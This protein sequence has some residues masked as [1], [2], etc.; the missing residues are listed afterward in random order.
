MFCQNQRA[1]SRHHGVAVIEV[2][3]WVSI[4]T[5]STQERIIIKSHEPLPDA[6]KPILPY[7][8]HLEL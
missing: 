4:G 5:G 7:V 3:D 1:V 2:K 6:W 8:D